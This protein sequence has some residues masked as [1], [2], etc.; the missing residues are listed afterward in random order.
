MNG[1][2]AGPAIQL[3]VSLE[4]IEPPIWRRL[5]MQIML[6]HQYQIVELPSGIHGRFQCTT[7]G[8]TLYSHLRS[9]AAL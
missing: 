1:N 2:K 8:I 4:V 5:L 3:K 7:I 9:R 6:T